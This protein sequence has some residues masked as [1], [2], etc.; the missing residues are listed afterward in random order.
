MTATFIDANHQELGVEPICNVLQVAPS[1]YGAHPLEKAARRAGHDTLAAAA[2]VKH[3]FDAERPNALWTTDLT[4]V[5]TRSGM[6]YVCFIVDSF[7]PMVVGCRVAAHMRTD[8]VLEALEMAWAHRG[9]QRLVGLITGCWLHW[10]NEQRRSHG[11]TGM[12][13]DVPPA[14]FEAAFSAALQTDQSLVGIQYPEPPSHPGR[15]ICPFSAQ[16]R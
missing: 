10:F 6:A 15:S 16:C 3:V 8:M 14:G 13:R 5:S 1:T 12:W 11:L 9:A 4:S 7:S 2:L